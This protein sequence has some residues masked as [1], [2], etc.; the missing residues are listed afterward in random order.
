MRRGTH[1]ELKG[2]IN[3]PGVI[4]ATFTDRNGKSRAVV[5]H[6]TNGAAGRLRIYEQNEL[7]VTREDDPPK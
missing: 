3:W 6:T 2:N 7:N 1:V 4:V 5:E